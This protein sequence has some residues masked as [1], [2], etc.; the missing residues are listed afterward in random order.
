MARVWIA[1]IAAADAAPEVAPPWLG[2][3]ERER[4][5]TLAPARQPGFVASRRLLRDALAQATG[6]AA[7][8]WRVSAE[9]GVVPKASR[10]DDDAARVPAVSIAHRLGWVAVAVGGSDD[11]AVGV[12]LECERPTR[13][14]PARRAA[15]VMA[16][17]ELAR[18]AALP[19]HEREPALLRAWVAREAW[20]K[21]G[22]AGT[23]WDFR[24]MACEP[25][26]ATRANVRT[27]EA[28]ALRVAL[29]APEPAAAA[30][31]GWPDAVGVASALWRVARR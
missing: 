4:W 13:S 16:G 11:D 21:A 12:D 25:A 15:L 31:E 27:W 20:F 2:P 7:G 6:V 22:G 19:A 30:C 17:D 8:H 29:C 1:R 14:D 10:V 23:P 9:A 26:D 3:A 5:A 18:W 24:R 28:G